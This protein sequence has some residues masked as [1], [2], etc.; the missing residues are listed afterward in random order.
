MFDIDFLRCLVS[1]KLGSDYKLAS[2]YEQINDDSEI[3]R[4]IETYKAIVNDENNV[5][6]KAW[7]VIR[8]EGNSEITNLY[9][10]YVISFD[11]SIYFKCKQ[12]NRDSVLIDLIKFIKE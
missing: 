3:D 2:Y 1:D 12:T 7:G 8:Q 9:Y 4:Y 10:N 5:N 11:W 6:N